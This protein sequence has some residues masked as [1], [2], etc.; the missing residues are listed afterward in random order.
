MSKGFTGVVEGRRH[1]SEGGDDWGSAVVSSRFS[2]L[3]EGR[4][5]AP[6]GSPVVI[7]CCGAVFDGA[8]L[9][10]GLCGREAGLA[11]GVERLVL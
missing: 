1:S 5:S 9:V 6:E 10:S 3:L 7:L 8:F 4:L 11:A 2:A